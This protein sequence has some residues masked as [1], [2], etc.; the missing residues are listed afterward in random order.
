M[1]SLPETFLDRVRRQLGEEF[2]AF[3]RAMEQDAVRGIR[4]NP[5]KPEGRGVYP[6]PAE[7]IPWEPDGYYLP[8]GETPGVTV[9]HEAGAFYL[10]DPAAMIQV[11]VLDPKPGEKILDLCAAPGGK[12]TQIGAALGGEGLLVCNEPVP[13]RAQVLSRNLERMGV[14][15]ALAVCHS[16]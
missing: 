15:N 2:P 8:A 7:G 14:V 11:R 10:Q 9:W 6:P 16:P 1:T 4:Y 3:L 12:S 5:L 13:K